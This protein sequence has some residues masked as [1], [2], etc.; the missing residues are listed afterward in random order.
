MKVRS[1]VFVVAVGIAALLGIGLWIP[2]S[3][4]QPKGLPP[5]PAGKVFLNLR[6]YGAIGDGKADDGPALQ[7]ALDALAVAG[8]GRL[9]VP[10]GR[11]LIKTPA[12]KDFFN[13]ASAIRIEGSG[14]AGQL[15][16][17]V[18]QGKTAIR[19]GNVDHLTIDGITF[20]GLPKVPVD[21]DI[22]VAVGGG[23][24]T[25]FR[26]CDFCGLS[27]GPAISAA[28]TDLLVARCTFLGC[29]NNRGGI[30]HNSQWRGVRVEDCRFL[31]YGTI[32]GSYR[33]IEAVSTRAWLLCEDAMDYPVS[34][35]RHQ[36]CVTVRNTLMDEGAAY[37]VFVNPTKG[38]V[39]RVHI[40]DLQDNVARSENGVGVY[41]RKVDYAVIENS[42]IG[43]STGAACDAVRLESVTSTRLERVL[44]LQSANRIT[45]DKACGKLTLEDCVYKTLNSAAKKTIGADGGK[46]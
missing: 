7:K 33:D 46:E 25:T 28:Q 12:E 42:F 26:D 43:Y 23:E 34:A 10:P 45:A 32:N 9:V 44:C 35:T 14:S 13:K 21:A 31:D 1:K 27:G 24:V 19:I 29:S 2:P 8:G 37:G 36:N 11:F 6:D 40:D 18:G 4:G 38:R 3:P 22:A 41:L 30:V 5:E 16:V 39:S 15:V 20:V 17:A